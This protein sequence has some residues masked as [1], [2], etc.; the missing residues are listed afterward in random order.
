M[1]TAA[2]QQGI[3]NVSKTVSDSVAKAEQVMTSSVQSV[4]STVQDFGSK[5][6]TGISNVDFLDTNSLVA[7]TIFILLLLIVF[8]ILLKFITY[9]I[10]Y[11]SSPKQN[12]YLI[13]DKN[14]YPGMIQGSDYQTIPRDPSMKGSKFLPRSNNKKTGI[15]FTWTFWLNLTKVNRSAEDGTN[16]YMHVFNVGNKDYDSD[17]LATINNGPGVYL[18]QYLNSDNTGTDPLNKGNNTGY[19]NMHIVMDTQYPGDD[20]TA[21]TYIDV[22]NL[23]YNK[24]FHVAIRVQNMS[25]DVYINGTVTQRLVFQNTP[26]QNYDDVQ[27]CMNSGFNGFL[28]ALQYHASALNVFDINTQV[29]W[30]PST[31]LISNNGKQANYD[32]LSSSWYFNKMGPQLV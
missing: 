8:V 3:S 5:T 16:K 32:Y 19:L 28:S 15:E 18:T 24:W 30:G 21:N 12:P 31:K 27:I 29:L 7:K 6:S 23:P 9:L 14:G 11:F 10:I 1:S 4:A 25:M 22:T 13:T 26:K 20:K 17:G 2:I